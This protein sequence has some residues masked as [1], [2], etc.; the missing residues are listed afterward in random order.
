VTGSGAARRGRCQSPRSGTILHCTH[1]DWARMKAAR[2]TALFVLLAL[3]ACGEKPPAPPNADYA[4]LR[5]LKLDDADA[6]ADARRAADA[7]DYRLLAVR[8]FTIEVPGAGDDVPK[9]EK[10]N[11]IKVI[12]GT[13]DMFENEE[14]RR[15]NEKAREYAKKYNETLL[16]LSKQASSSRR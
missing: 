9:I 3:S 8:G 12:P 13:S 6:A 5:A 4:E 15:L 16:V 14:H 10:E 2:A 11:G 1:D 7:K